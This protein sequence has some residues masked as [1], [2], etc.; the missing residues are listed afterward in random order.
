MFIA[1]EGPNGVGK[2][3]ITTA[4]SRYLAVR[5][6]TLE[7]YTTR[8]PTESPLGQAIRA[9]ESQL[10]GRALGL[11]CAA[12]RAYHVAAEIGP[13]LERGAWVIS[14]RYLPS[15]LVLQRIDGLETADVWEMNNTVPAPDLTVYL[16]DDPERIAQRLSER[17][18]RTRLES[19]ATADRELTLYREARAF[20]DARGWRGLVIDGAGRSPAELASGIAAA[21]GR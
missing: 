10:L 6:P 15:S 3:A 14:D 21:V 1:I 20:L 9:M 19:R 17:P 12:D 18:R 13:A 4:L 7:V 16:E 2:S 11:A 8:E 5:A